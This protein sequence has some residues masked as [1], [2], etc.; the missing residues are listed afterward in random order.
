V[1]KVPVGDSGVETMVADESADEY[2]CD[3]RV[4]GGILDAM[5]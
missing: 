5:P 1:T 2:G 4:N 3:I